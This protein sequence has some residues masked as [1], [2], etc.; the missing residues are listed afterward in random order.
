[1]VITR[2]TMENRVESLEQAF[3]EWRLESDRT[4]HEWRVAQQNQMDELRQLLRPGRRRRR[5]RTRP[6]DDDSQVSDGGGS[7]SRSRVRAEV[8]PPPPPYGGRKMEVPVFNG[9]DAYGWL[10]RVER[11]FRLNAI[12][13]G[14][15]VD[16]IILAMEGRALNWYQW[17]EEQTSDM[18]WAEFKRAVLRRFQPGLVQNPLGP[19]LSI[20]QTGTVMQYREQFE[21]LIAPLQRDERVMLNSIFING[22]QEEIQAELRLHETRSLADLMDKA[23]LIEEKIWASQRGKGVSRE[24]GD[25][26]SKGGAWRNRGGASGSEGGSFRP[27]TVRPTAVQSDTG[28]SKTESVAG[29]K[30]SGLGKKLSQEELSDLSRKGLCFKC[31][32]KWGKEHVCK[33][34][35]FQL[36]LCEGDVDE[37]SETEA[38][39]EDEVA[40]EVKTLQLSLKSKEGL[41]SNQSFKLWGS[42]QGREVLILVDSGASSNFI[43][44]KLVAELALNV[45]HTSAYTVE[46]GSGELVSNQ[47]VCQ[48][49]A[50]VVQGITFHQNFF[51]MNLGGTE[52]V[53]G[54]DWLASLGDIEANFRNLIIKWGSG[55][56]KRILRGDPALCKGTASLK[57]LLKA[58]QNEGECYYV[59]YYQ[60]LKT[61]SVEEGLPPHWESVLQGFSDVFRDP[62]GLPPKR[63]CDHAIVLREGAQIPNCRPYRYPYYQKNEIEKFVTEML[64]AGII[65]PSTSP[66]SSPVIL[67][68]KKRWGM[69]VLHRL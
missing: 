34:K 31:G 15:K 60:L 41:T 37:Q 65:R 52:V 4:F 6:R 57:T 22:L 51:M 64:H 56:A 42:I 29:E 43:S 20:R 27:N 5:G 44:P 47:G 59:D 54:M 21:L 12:R 53:L 23:L 11:Y 45:H 26:G 66:F 28:G 62:K 46:L 67:V 24:K 36:V 17:W 49:V 40:F 7:R 32:E 8:T 10:V 39:K 55:S 38:E 19:L 68:K 48:D 25:W 14:E 3:H 33:F 58:M 13:E 50:F 63:S 1:M 9:G 61:E 69:A 2:N 16:A 18:S 35:H 30:K